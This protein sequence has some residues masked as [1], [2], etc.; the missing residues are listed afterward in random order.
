MK[1]ISRADDLARKGAKQ[2][3][4]LRTGVLVMHTYLTNRLN[5]LEQKSFRRM[6]KWKCRYKPFKVI[7]MHRFETIK[8]NYE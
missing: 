5:E 1:Q 7:E 2:R 4:S 8:G 6:R 3:T